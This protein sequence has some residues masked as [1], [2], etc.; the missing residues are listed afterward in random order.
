MEATHTN[1]LV[2]EKSPYLLQHA[3]NP[4]DWY[5]WGREAFDVA[6]RENKPIFL[7]VGYSTCHWCHVMERESFEDEDIAKVMNENFVNI[8]VD[9]EE[10][11]DVDRVY[12][13]FVQAT[14][15][16]G[17][18][19][20]STFLTP[21]LKPF[22]GGTYY[23]P[24][25]K[26][27]RPGFKS[28]LH[29]IGSLWRNNRESVI[30]QAD[31]IMEQ[32]A[33][34]FSGKG[35]S[36]ASSTSESS[37]NNKVES[38]MAKAQ[39][40]L[41]KGA[42]KFQS[43]YD[44]K[45][46]GFGGAPKFPRPVVLNFMLSVAHR[47]LM[48]S[49]A[50]AGDQKNV[51][52]LKRA[53]LI[54]SMCK[55]TL[56][57]MFR[58]G[59]FDHLGGGFHRYSV[60]E[61]WHIPHFEKMGYDQGQLLN[62]YIDAYQISGDSTFEQ[63][64]RETLLYAMRDM[65]HTEGGGLYSAED[66]DSLSVGAMHK[67]EGAFYLWSYQELSEIVP[68]DMPLLEYIYGIKKD[69]N[70]RSVSDPHHE[71]R[72]MNHLFLQHTIEEAALQFNK[73][74]E[75]IR[76]RL[77]EARRKLFEVRSQRS[78]PSLDDKIIT[79]WNGLYISAFARAYQI[80]EDE[81]YLGVAEET[82]RFIMNQLYDPTQKVLLRS[83]REGPA[84]IHGYLQD[85]AYLIMGLLD[86]YECG[87][88]SA[89]DWLTWAIQLQTKQTELFED[90]ENGGFYD[91]AGDDPSILIRFK[92]DQDMAEPAG[93]SVAA[94]NLYRLY[95]LTGDES[96]L[97]SAQ[98]SVASFEEEI[99]NVPT[100][101]PQMLCALNLLASAPVYIVIQGDPSNRDTQSMLRETRKHFIPNKVLLFTDMPRGQ[102]STV[103]STVTGKQFGEGVGTWIGSD[104]NQS[105]TSCSTVDQL[106]TAL[107][108]YALSVN[109]L[110][111][112]GMTQTAE[113]R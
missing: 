38:I 73:S 18:W 103:L 9:R 60:D 41:L 12:M 57:S 19:P 82:A 35:K 5:P 62:S 71:M 65:Y 53:Q 107:S 50:T 84:N 92:G 28:I 52:E 2:H 36:K 113:S 49:T 42:L 81:M 10:R 34:A 37:V 79:A 54:W 51:A 72:G 46:G 48:A 1:R 64:I 76:E 83:F 26:Y 4:V 17:G 7:S 45:Y 30:E 104:L 105:G 95:R 31:D 47:L 87:S 8:K 66:A 25:D 43:E 21:T 63:V 59:M 14:T 112:V 67:K 74:Q 102:V 6:K 77:D 93:T 61:F 106:R 99:R 97:R 55:T 29:R 20:M 44:R 88:A 75:Q 109:A 70:I 58:G 69:G 33:N 85:Y 100:A 40:L 23:P 39:G 3:H 98:A 90:Q 111:S 32:I 94:M 11:P 22:F 27:G 24:Q 108:R 68:E 86:L 91:V 96:Y 101:V 110:E 15:G 78:R 80:F 13:T 16:S 89:M 56:L